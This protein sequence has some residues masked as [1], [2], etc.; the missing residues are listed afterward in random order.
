MPSARRKMMNI[1]RHEINH[2]KLMF[3]TYPV[4]ATNKMAEQYAGLDFST[5]N[6]ILRGTIKLQYKGTDGMKICQS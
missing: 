5:I 4:A 3:Q 2:L 1:H 6:G